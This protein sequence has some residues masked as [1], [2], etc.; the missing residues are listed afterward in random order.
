ML[1]GAGGGTVSSSFS[2]LREAEAKLKEVVR[3]SMA[4][5]MATGDHTEV[6]RSSSPAGQTADES[7]K[8]FNFR[9]FKIFPLLNLHKEGLQ[10]FSSHLRRQVRGGGDILLPALSSLFLLHR[11]ENLQREVWTKPPSLQV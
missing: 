3:T 1:H 7:L 8:D 11:S 9:F 5:A 4:D 2:L 6:E 10:L